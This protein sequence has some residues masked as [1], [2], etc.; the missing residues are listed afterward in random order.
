MA[1]KKTPPQTG[2]K[3]RITLKSFDHKLIDD[4]A[5]IIYETAERTGAIVSGPIPLP[6]KI[7]KITLNKSTFV[8]KDSREQYEI[9][10]HKR[11]VDVMEATP[12]TIESLSSLHLPA[13]VEVSIKMMAMA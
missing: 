2:Q 5:K 7:K 4:A 1:T 9:R 12:Q 8:H 6:V 11:L 13:G 10:V 3:I